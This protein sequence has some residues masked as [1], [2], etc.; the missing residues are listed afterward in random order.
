MHIDLYFAC[1]IWVA[2]MARNSCESFLSCSLVTTVTFGILRVIR[3]WYVLMMIYYS[4]T[5][6]LVI[7]LIYISHRHHCRCLHSSLCRMNRWVDHQWLCVALLDHTCN[8]DTNEL[9]YISFNVYVHFTVA[10]LRTSVACKW[11]LFTVSVYRYD[12]TYVIVIACVYVYWYYFIIWVL[13]YGQPS[14]FHSTQT[15]EITWNDHCIQ[16]FTWYAGLKYLLT[17]RHLYFTNTILDYHD[18]N[19]YSQTRTYLSQIS[20]ISD[21]T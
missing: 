14:R 12:N 18:T 7:V 3:W 13:I 9:Y 8:H 6:T 11:I 5:L 17:R 19:R 10:M 20:T 4:E 16:L 15:F 2:M 1:K 21:V